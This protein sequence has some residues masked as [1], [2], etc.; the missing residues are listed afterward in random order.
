[1]AVRAAARGLWTMPLSSCCLKRPVRNGLVL[2][3]GGADVDRIAEGA[4]ELRDLLGA[5]PE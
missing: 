4:R 1:M 5:C 2:G 3:F